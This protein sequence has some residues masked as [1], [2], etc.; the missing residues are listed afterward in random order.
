Y[1]CIIIHLYK[2]MSKLDLSAL[3]GKAK[4]TNMTSPVQ[5]VVPVK[6]KIK[7]TPFNVHFP[8]DV[9]K[10]LKMLSVEKGTTMKNLIVTAVQEKYF[11]K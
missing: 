8:D 11:N 1:I 6:N 7:E 4:E 10:S 5:K 2:T 3:I 9:L